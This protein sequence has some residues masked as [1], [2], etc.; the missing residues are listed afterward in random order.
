[1]QVNISF[2]GTASGQPVLPDM[3]EAAGST[4]PVSDGGGAPG[5]G[6]DSG[7]DVSVAY[8]VTEAGTYENIGAPPAWLHEAIAAYHVATASGQGAAAA[9]DDVMDGGQGPGE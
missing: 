2:H 4:A 1:M 5:A 9:G 6:A 8:E 7:S 3:Q